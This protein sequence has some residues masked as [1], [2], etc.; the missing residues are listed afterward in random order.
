MAGLHELRCIPCRAGEPA[1]NDK[2]IAEY[3]SQTPGW[4]VVEIEGVKRLRR[5]FQFKNFAQALEFTN[6]IGGIAEEQGHHPRLVTEW[7]KA[8]VDWW[9]HIIGGL[10]KNDFIMAAR[11]STEYSER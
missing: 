4:E 10:H 7:G 3:L 9:T 11:T 8:T 2:E 5:S 6:R 1:L